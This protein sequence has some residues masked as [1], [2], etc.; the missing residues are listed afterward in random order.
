MTTYSG[1]R[2]TLQL[3]ERL[4]LEWAKY[5]CETVNGRY[6]LGLH[7]EMRETG[8]DDKVR[9]TS[10]LPILYVHGNEVMLRMSFS[11]S[12]RKLMVDRSAWERWCRQNGLVLKLETPLMGAQSIA[13]SG[14]RGD[15]QGSEVG[16]KMYR[17]V[18]MAKRVWTDAVRLAKAPLLQK[19]KQNYQE[20]C[21][22]RYCTEVSTI[23]QYRIHYEPPK[24][25]HGEYGHGAKTFT[26]TDLG[27]RRLETEEELAAFALAYVMVT[28]NYRPEEY[29]PD[30]MQWNLEFFRDDRGVLF[31]RD[32][33]KI[34]GTSKTPPPPP[35]PPAP[36]PKDLY[37]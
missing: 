17:G 6:E 14:S 21:A 30:Y 11:G 12:A 8:W 23:D 31:I 34:H 36:K 28:G 18:P 25:G 10:S 15:W 37:E 16:Q 7:R 5:D 27:Y 13:V 22:N 20:A 4:Y 26:I 33:P 29:Y 35:P 1:F 32:L 3:F 9:R 24:L 19:A 2:E